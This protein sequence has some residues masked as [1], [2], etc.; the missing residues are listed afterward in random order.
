MSRWSRTSAAVVLALASLA[1]LALSA[2]AGPNGRWTQITHQHNG[3]RGNLG[4]ARTKDG[5]LHVLWAGPNRAP[6]NAILDTTISPAGTV[7]NPQPVLSG[8]SAVNTPT[9]ATAA[10]GSIHAIV[11]GSKVGTQNDPTNGLNE[12]VGPGTW[13]VG[14]R[15]FGNASITVASNADVH[16]AFLKSGQLIS[17]WQTAASLLFETGT[18]AAVPPQVITPQGLAVNPVIAVD[19]KSGE[20]VIAYN[21]V[22]E[23]TVYF[24]RLA[25]TLGTP[26]AI[27][28]NKTDGPT[29]AARSTGGIFTAY[30]DRTRA[31]LL[32]YGGKARNV[33]MPKGARALTAGLAAG[34]DGRLWVFFGDEQK[35]YVTRSSRHVTGWEPVQT[36]ASPPKAVQYFRLE[37]EGS[38][39][40]LDLFA[41]VT[42]DGQTNDGSY[43]TQVRPKLSLGTA[44]KRSKGGAALVTV[45]VTDAGDAVAGATVK[46]LPG[47][48]KTTDAKGA[49]AVRVGKGGT[50]TLTATK[51]GYVSATAKLSV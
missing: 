34:P 2:N 24:R 33:P 11:S 26:H 38:A 35:T 47:G 37:G 12:V 39:G 43:H 16:T 46:G 41:D 48:T 9:A 49:I 19:Q 30:V 15:A 28:R 27:P 8:W 45:R 25:P 7:G 23:D 3:A 40:P 21:N 6:F 5:R 18:D 1:A 22:K 50:L 36:L 17:V 14:A 13:K 20:A 10:D 4:L 32:Q 51:P 44:K 31:V 29:I 42:V